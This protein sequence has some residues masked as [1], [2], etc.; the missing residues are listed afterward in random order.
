MKEKSK[1]LQLLHDKSECEN[2]IYTYM[3]KKDKIVKEIEEMTNSFS[4]VKPLIVNA[5]LE[6][7]DKEYIAK[8]MEDRKMMARGFTNNKVE[9]ATTQDVEE[10]YG[11]SAYYASNIF[12]P[13]HDDFVIYNYLYNEDYTKVRFNVECTKLRQYLG[14]TGSWI[15][16]IFPSTWIDINDLRKAEEQ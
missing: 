7:M 3:E 11:S 15:P 9:W 6:N 2:T 1:L 13:E 14:I 8:I 10:N 12:D 4:K 16:T 5:L